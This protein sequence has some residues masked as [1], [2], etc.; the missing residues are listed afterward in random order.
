MNRTAAIILNYN[1]Y[2]DTIK[3]ITNLYKINA[4]VD[5]VVVDNASTNNSIEMINDAFIG[6]E[7]FYLLENNK[8]TGY[9][10]G[11]N[12]G[13]KFASDKLTHVEFMCIMNPDTIIDTPDVIRRLE[14]AL[15]KKEIYV[16]YFHG[17]W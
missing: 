12:I 7:N 11:N 14:A 8:N 10:A 1:S 9:A 3:C 15:D 4:E 16:L 17:R 13:L 5:V 2:Q 6:K